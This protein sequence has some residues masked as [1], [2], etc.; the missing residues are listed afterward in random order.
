MPT[1]GVDYEKIEINEA[2]PRSNWVRRIL[3]D[4]FKIRC[5]TV[6][7][8]GQLLSDVFRLFPLFFIEIRIPNLLSSGRIYKIGN[9]GIRSIRSVHIRRDPG[10]SGVRKSSEFAA[11]NDS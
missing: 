8:S 3:S 10:L 5:Y 4:G 1:I 6:I 2:S 7:G 9:D 11:L